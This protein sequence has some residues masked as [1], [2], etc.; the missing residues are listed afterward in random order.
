MIE[1]S[2]YRFGKRVLIEHNAGHPVSLHTYHDPHLAAV[3]LKMFFRDLPT[4]I[5]PEECYAI[6]KRCPPPSDQDGDMACITYIRES[7]LPALTSYCTVIVLSYVLS[8]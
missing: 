1:V 5:F 7:I 2:R 4:P 3:L 6:V 8:M